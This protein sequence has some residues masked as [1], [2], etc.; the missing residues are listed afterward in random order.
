MPEHARTSMEWMDDLIAERKGTMTMK[1][2]KAAFARQHAP[3]SWSA[4]T[5]D[6]QDGLYAALRDV[7]GILE[8]VR[9]AK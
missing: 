3:R 1:Q 6:E 2:A 8:S 9:E 7:D 4:L 5:P